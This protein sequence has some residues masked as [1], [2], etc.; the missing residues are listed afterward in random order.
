[1]IIDKKY[2]MSSYL[3]L[4]TIADDTKGFSEK[5][6]PLLIPINKDRHPV[7]DSFEL[8]AMLK[9]YTE[10]AYKN[11]KVALCLSGGIDSAILAKFAP[12]GTVCYTFKCVVPGIEVTNEVPQA[13]IY[14][15]ECG[16]EQRVIEVYWED[17]EALAPILM[18]HKGA[19]IHS[20][21]VQIYKA[22]LQAK[23]DGFD[24]LL[25]GETADVNFGGFD[26][27]LSKDWNLEDFKKRY[28]NIEPSIVL[29]D[30]V[31]IK[32]PFEKYVVNGV[33]DVHEF[34]RHVFYREAINS[35]TNACSTAGVEFISPYTKT[36]LSTPLDLERIRNG[37]NKY[38]VREVFHRLYPH[39][40]IPKKIP[41]PR[42]T[43]EWLKDWKCKPRE[44]FRDDID[45]SKLKGDQKWLIYALD[46][47]L[48]IIK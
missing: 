8:E 1:M 44:E 4:R 7:A 43:N 47:F 23:K 35:Y 46:K 29:K 24:A 33:V 14:A 39:L 16:L 10:E 3:T 11:H 36:F 20:I 6:P 42:A 9:K 40:D 26:G 15:K 30:Y 28:T 5:Y 25:F 37:E 2:C 31:D 19:P 45:Y 22:A 12:K 32:E 38:I 34:V 21:E 13:S 27:L 48:D 41:M 18:K 17:F